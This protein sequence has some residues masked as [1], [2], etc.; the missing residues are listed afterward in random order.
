[1]KRRTFFG[2]VGSAAAASAASSSNAETG[3]D[4]YE[5]LGVTKIIN[6]A[7]HVHG[8]DRVDHAALGAGGGGARGQTSGAAGGAAEGGGRIP[9]Q[10]AEVRGGDGDGRRGFGADAGH[11]G[12]HDVGEQVRHPRHPDR[13]A[14]PRRTK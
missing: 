14:R 9:C 6:A 12:V 11:G 2:T 7:G 3:E 10:E 5:K 8:S 13:G 1:M 4:Y